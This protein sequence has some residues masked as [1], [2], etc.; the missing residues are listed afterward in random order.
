MYAALFNRFAQLSERLAF[1]RRREVQI[2]VIKKKIDRYDVICGNL[3]CLLIGN[4]LDL[5]LL[6]R[7]VKVLHGLPDEVA[8]LIL[9]NMIRHSKTCLLLH[10]VSELIFRNVGG[11]QV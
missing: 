6:Q 9:G 11:A 1:A 5:F 2:N 10:L 8:E 4:H 7:N 3:A